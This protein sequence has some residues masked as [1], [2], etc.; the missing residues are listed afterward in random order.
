MLRADADQ[1]LSLKV[2]LQKWREG[3]SA[4]RAEDV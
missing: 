1:I 3:T 2:E 4:Q